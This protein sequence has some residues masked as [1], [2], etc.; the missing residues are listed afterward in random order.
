MT[1]YILRTTISRNCVHI[2]MFKIMVFRFVTTY[3]KLCGFCFCLG[4][5]GKIYFPKNENYWKFDPERK[6]HVRKSQYP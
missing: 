4:R 2:T 5:D 3:S 1:K 6:P